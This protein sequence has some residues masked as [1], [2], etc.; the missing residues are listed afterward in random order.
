VISLQSRRNKTYCFILIICLLTSCVCVGGFQADG[1]VNSFVATNQSGQM[2]TATDTISNEDVCTVEMLGNTQTSLFSH[3]ITSRNSETQNKS[4]SLFLLLAAFVFLQS[5]F[6]FY[7]SAS[8]GIYVVT[9]D[10]AEIIH[11]I[12]DK[13]GKKKI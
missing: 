5:L 6:R 9:T 13:D 2:M 10:V 11:F 12:H 4:E 3:Q 1:Q 7:T 8:S